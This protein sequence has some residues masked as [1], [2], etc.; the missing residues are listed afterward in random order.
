M[1]NDRRF[2]RQIAQNG[3]STDPGAEVTSI[4]AW[5]PYSLYQLRSDGFFLI[6]LAGWIVLIWVA[7]L[8][9]LAH[10]SLVDWPTIGA[11]AGLLILTKGIE[12]SGAV[13]RTGMW[14]ISSMATERAAALCLVLTAALLSMLLTNDVALFVV[15][16]LTLDMC[17]VTRLPATRLI[18]FQA[19]AVNVGSTLT[20][21]GNPQ[22]LFLWQQWGI[23]FSQFV[24]EMSPLVAVLLVLLVVLTASCFSGRRLQ[25]HGGRAAPALDQRLLGVSLILY[26]PFLLLTD[27]DHPGFAVAAVALIYL[28]L[29]PRLLMQIDWGLLLVFM[30]MFIDLRL[31][32]DLGPVRE[33]IAGLDLAQPRHL[34]FAGIAASQFISNVPAAIALAEYSDHW[35]VIAFGVAVGGFGFVIGSLA[36]LI[37][38]RMTDDRHAWISFHA[39]SLLF[40][41]A[42]ALSGY[43][44]LFWRP[45]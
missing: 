24:L 4:P 14:I 13:H 11:L 38:L 28:A 27:L 10:A 21:I 42:A 45:I 2:A 1:L 7:P 23:S 40:L 43:A 37:A 32:A 31:F 26:V 30:L 5:L 39:Y 15:V 29:R 44:V 6:L 41:A 16:P 33:A 20:P 18:I 34:Y 36:N 17:R 9:L 19:L 35:R 22:N 25:A 12:A 3:T 8:P